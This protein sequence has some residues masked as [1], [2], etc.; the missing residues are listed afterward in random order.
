M[1]I[2]GTFWAIVC[3]SGLRTFLTAVIFIPGYLIYGFW[4][5][6]SF[7]AG[8]K[9]I[10]FYLWLFSACWHSVFIFGIFLT[11]FFFQGIWLVLITLYGFVGCLLSLL[12]AINEYNEMK[13]KP[14]SSPN[15]SQ[16]LRD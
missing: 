4:I 12:G 1:W 13:G 3:L 16:S 15:S 7:R 10:T 5:Y 14:R 11:M 9:R 6:R 8:D 2:L